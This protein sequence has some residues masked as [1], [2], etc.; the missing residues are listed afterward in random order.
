MVAPHKRRISG[1]GVMIHPNSA[2]EATLVSP[3]EG[4]DLTGPKPTESKTGDTEKQQAFP[5]WQSAPLVLILF[6]FWV[7]L[8]G[9]LDAFHLGAGALCSLAIGWYSARL[10][11]LNPALG[12]PGQHPILAVP[13]TRFITYLPWL[14]FEIV[15]AALQVVR[16][17]YSPRP[18][19]RPR[20]FWTKCKLPHSIA[21]LTLANSITL[22]PGTVT[23]DVDGDD[24]LVHALTESSASE[25]ERDDA[26][27]K[28]AIQR[29][30]PSE[31]AD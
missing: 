12:R 20:L 24:F 13:F 21:R 30:Y 2:P 19:L 7:L 26:P 11:R 3:L 15:V 22:T 31:G 23:V 9:K 17:V 6:G 1:G 27:M 29:L 18:D 16:V 25:L 4:M 10:F 8:S 28:S 5:V 14:A